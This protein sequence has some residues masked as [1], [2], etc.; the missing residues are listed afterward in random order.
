VGGR[1][2]PGERLYRTL[3]ILGTPLRSW[4]RLEVRGLEALRE[5]GGIL[6]VAN[7]DSWLDPLALGETCMRVRRPLRFLAKAGLWRNPLIARLL[8]G[9]R[10]IPIQR[11][12]GDLAALEV[13]TSALADG[14]TVC[15][16]PEGTISR[17]ERLRARR[18]VARLAEAAPEARIVL[19][20]VTGG[21][22]LA[23]FPRRP[24]VTVELFAARSGPPRPGEDHQALADRLLDEIRER[25]APVPAGRRAARP[26]VTRVAAG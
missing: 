16:F 4:C 19:A 20:A 3:V 15:I 6:L 14:E 17:G 8:D 2:A 21:T 26:A 23:R 24:R 13:A 25:V 9:I 11:G 10:Q 18:G 22:D 1:R 7:H 5:P 12:A